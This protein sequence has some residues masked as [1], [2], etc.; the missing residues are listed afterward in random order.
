MKNKTLR[1]ILDQDSQKQNDLLWLFSRSF[2]PGGIS[3]D[4]DLSL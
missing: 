1:E 3:E 4:C 2:D